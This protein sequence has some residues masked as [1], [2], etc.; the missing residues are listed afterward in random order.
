MSLKHANEAAVTTAFVEMRR[1]STRST[2][3]PLYIPYFDKLC[4]ALSNSFWAPYSGNR[5]FAEQQKLYQKGRTR[6]SIDRNQTIVTNAK[7]GDSAHNWGCATDWAEFVPGYVSQEVWTKADWG[8]FSRAVESV[9]LVWGG[10]FKNFKDKPHCELPIKV[11]WK[12]IGSVYRTSGE[13]AARKEI[14]LQIR[15]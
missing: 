11:S 2:L 9:G 10:N 7:A 12:V 3:S 4:E 1:E 14:E 13:V 8:V 6:E 5:S 15:G